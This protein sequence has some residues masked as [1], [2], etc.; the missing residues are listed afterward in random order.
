M[1]KII[2]KKD[3]LILLLLIVIALILDLVFFSNTLED[4][5]ITY[6]YSLRFSEGYE[7]GMWNRTGSPVE[8]FTTFL[9]MIYLSLFGPNIDTIV[10]TSKITTILSHISIIILFFILSIKFENN[11]NININ[12]FKGDEEISSK[13]FL[14]TSIA[15]AVFLPIS[16]YATTGMETV[17]FITLIA[18]IFFVPMLTSNII[19]LS[20]LTILLVLIRPDG[21]MFAIASPLYYFWVTRDRKFII[22]VLVALASFIALAIFRYS[23]FGYFMPNTYYAKSANA[24]GF[25]HLKAGILYFGTFFTTYI[26]MFMPIFMM[27]IATNTLKKTRERSF[28]LLLLLGGTIYFII[29]ARAGADN[30]SA[31]PM[32][33][34]ALNVFP[35]LA[36]CTFW[37]IYSIY[38]KFGKLLSIFIIV[39]LFSVPIFLSIPMSQSNFLKNQLFNSATN[40]PNFS[41]HYK[42]NHLL[43]WLKSI[44]DKNTTIATSLA[45]ALPLT[46]DAYH[47][48]ILGLNDEYIAHNGMFDPNGPTDSKTD[49]NYL[50]SLRPDIIEGHMNAENIITGNLKPLPKWRRKMNY[51]LI[52]NPIFQNEYL[53][54]TNAPYKAFNRVLFIRKDYYEKIT[55][56]FN[57]DVISVDRLVEIIK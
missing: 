30:F 52:A 53:I 45:G 8:G 16:W 57:I 54:I 36:F 9:W 21:I 51:N 14:F 48:D 56:K 27:L 35:L 26:Y 13:A 34:H 40:F 22:I 50:L 47:I 44:T 19:V 20:L 39:L 5:Q 3:Y 6:R 11:K 49:M 18:Y 43:L 31:F 38:D 10:Y 55:K 25:M 42:S 32:W 41:N 46:V 7:F 37:S 24:V 29:L 17:L 12:I 28:I 4:A 23:Y 2:L 33:R 1:N 15:M